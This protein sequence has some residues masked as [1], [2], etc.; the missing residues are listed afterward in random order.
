[1]TEPNH[2]KEPAMSRRKML[3]ALGL[4]GAAM[5]FGRAAAS[6]SSV[7]DSVYGTKK[8]C[9]CAN[10]RSVDELRT[11]A[12]D[13]AGE[14]VVLEG[15]YGSTPGVGGGILVAVQGGF[16]DDG[17]SLFQSG[18]PGWF[19]K[20]TGSFLTVEDFGVARGSDTSA[21]ARN[22]ERLTAAF[23]VT[24]YTVSAT[25]RMTYIY[26][27]DVI[28]A[29]ASMLDCRKAVFQGI[30]GCIRIASTGC[31]VHS[32]VLDDSLRTDN[33]RAMLIEA[34][35]VQVVHA[36]FRGN[37]HQECCL[38]ITGS[39]VSVSH[40]RLRDASYM[41]LATTGRGTRITGNYFTGGNSKAVL[42]EARTV[43]TTVPW[44]DAIKLTSDPNDL[45]NNH[46]T[47]RHDNIITGN[48]F[49]DVYRDCVDMFTDGSRTIFSH[50]VIT[51]HHW[52]ILDIKCIYRDLPVN[53]TSLNPGRREESVIA[54]GNLIKNVDN[55]Y[56][57][58]ESLFSVVHYKNPESGG[59]VTDYGLGPNKIKIYGNSIDGA[60]GYVFR[61]LDSH[62]VS[63]CDNEH[64]NM[65]NNAVYIT[66]ESGTR[67][68]DVDRNKFYYANGKDNWGNPLQVI[69]RTSA[70]CTR[71]SVSGNTFVCYKKDGFRGAVAAVV[72]GNRM[73][74]KGNTGEGFDIV[75]DAARGTDLLCDGTVAHDGKI[76]VRVGQYGTVTGARVS[77]TYASSCVQV[78]AV[79]TAN[80]AKLIMVDNDGIDISGTAYSDV[81]AIVNRV[82]R[83]NSVM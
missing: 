49:D 40:S 31:V 12:P 38:E 34:D 18:K 58:G 33:R 4:A 57:S 35:H 44:G 7:M 77:G 43:A 10:V 46:A 82:E 79:H 73:T 81:S 25:P 65:I 21:A 32:P 59:K 71:G 36:E 11:R 39:S 61:A 56:A 9:E 6:G 68:I 78:V 69:R 83:N 14:Q 52:N 55:P 80:T 64:F 28:V 75:V 22:A 37:G 42:N 3:A 62:D 17:G 1:M 29:S 72:M 48:I 54:A 66:G 76:A 50:N 15:Y 74:A 5:S 63:Y 24:G 26:D 67:H 47:G 16:T 23:Q 51:N 60:F 70:N 53:G 13:C 20:R 30:T 45:A 2:E 41:I 27:G 8:R 19:W